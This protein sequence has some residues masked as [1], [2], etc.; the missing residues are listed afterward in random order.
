[1]ISSLYYNTA[2][3][4]SSRFWNTRAGSARDFTALAPFCG[5]FFERISAPP[6]D[7]YCNKQKMDI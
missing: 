4:L 7:L 3:R 2:G 6:E 5:L 1:M